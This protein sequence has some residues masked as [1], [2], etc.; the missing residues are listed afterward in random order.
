MSGY[1]VLTGARAYMD[2]WSGTE[3]TMATITGQQPL[4]A[5][6]AHVIRFAESAE[7]GSW[8]HDAMGLVFERYACDESCPARPDWDK[9]RADLFVVL[10]KR[11]DDRMSDLIDELAADWT[12]ALERFRAEHPEAPLVSPEGTAA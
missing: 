6:I 9:A 7:P 12:I 4:E 11:A 8:L 10:A 3:D 5:R 2:L 1:W